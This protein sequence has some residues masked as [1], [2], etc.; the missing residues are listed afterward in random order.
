MS[1]ELTGKFIV[2]D[3]L[4]TITWTRREGLVATDG[5][6]SWQPTLEQIEEHYTP[7]SSIADR[8]CDLVERRR[9]K[10]EQEK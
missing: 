9:E 4:V 3:S 8:F 2:A 6:S 1:D 5:E 10:H 7:V